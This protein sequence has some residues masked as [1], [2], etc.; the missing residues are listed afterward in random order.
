ML[1]VLLFFWLILF[2]YSAVAVAHDLA[3]TPIET[4]T[5][6]PE[7][8]P[9][10]TTST[11]VPEPTATP[12]PTTEPASSTS[13]SSTTPTSVAKPTLKQTT[14]TQTSGFVGNGLVEEK[15]NDTGLGYGKDKVLGAATPQTVSSAG[16]KD[17]LS[18]LIF[19]TTAVILVVWTTYMILVQKGIIKSDLKKDKPTGGITPQPLN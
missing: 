15:E 3:P 5:V 6:T 18:T 1:T 13:N 19:L 10:P 12:V 9:V 16:D 14:K 7:E 17:L 2:P 4:P 11:P 8:T